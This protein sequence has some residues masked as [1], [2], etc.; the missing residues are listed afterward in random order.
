[1]TYIDEKI[2]AFYIAAPPGCCCCLVLHDTFDRTTQS[3]GADGVNVRTVKRYASSSL[4]D[5]WE[6]PIDEGYLLCKTD[7]SPVK[8]MELPAGQFLNC[9]AEVRFDDVYATAT[10]SAGPFSAKVS[11]PTANSIKLEFLSG[12]SW[13][14]KRPLNFTFPMTETFGLEIYDKPTYDEADEDESPEDA[15]CHPY[16][17]SAVAIVGS[18]N[19]L[20]AACCLA[21]GALDKSTFTDYTLAAT[22]GVRFNYLRVTKAKPECKEPVGLACQYSCY[23][24]L[25]PE[26]LTLKVRGYNNAHYTCIDN[27]GAASKCV[28]AHAQACVDAQAA[29]STVHQACLDACADDPCREA[30]NAARGACLSALE[31]EGGACDPGW[32]GCV[33]CYAPRKECRVVCPCE[34]INGDYALERQLVPM[35]GAFDVQGAS[36]EYG[37]CRC[38]YWGAFPFD[39]DWRPSLGGQF[40]D[41]N[42]PQTL[43]QALNGA[44]YDR[45]AYLVFHVAYTAHYFDCVAGKM[46]YSMTL[47]PSPF[48]LNP[49]S[50]VTSPLLA[51]DFCA[52]TEIDFGSSRPAFGFTVFTKQLSNG[53]Y[54]PAAGCTCFA[55]SF[56][57]GP[58]GSSE[59]SCTSSD[60]YLPI[61]QT[62]DV[63]VQS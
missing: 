45:N 8:F 37:E 50:P 41:C 9:L 6:V 61:A 10:I 25:L 7:D 62:G 57:L 47:I 22:A 15:F 27:P 19:R 58:C 31:E 38:I 12:D 33:N 11:F 16:A 14:Y 26:V 44:T 51:E 5:D 17:D 29:C 53:A 24:D 32:D 54:V 21:L 35:P 1:M 39:N 13:T 34:D 55:P 30:C 49:I 20:G 52:G 60:E 28:L 23:P 2:Q 18:I 42:S 59:E 63:K 48:S 56:F 36:S 40:N 4:T 43:Y 46:H 3:R